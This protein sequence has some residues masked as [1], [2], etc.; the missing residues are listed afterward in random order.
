MKK[1]QHKD[2]VS[3]NIEYYKHSSSLKV[4]DHDKR[5]IPNDENVYQELSHN[6]FGVIFKDYKEAYKN[7]G[8]AIGK[9]VAKNA[10][11]MIDCVVSFSHDQFKLLM[12]DKPNNYKG[13]LLNHLKML[14]LK[15]QNEYGFEPLSIDF[16]MDEGKPLPDGSIENNYHAH[17]TFYNYDH[18]KKCA[19]LRKY[20]N[21]KSAFSKLQ[22]MT[23][24]VFAGLGFQRGVSKKITKKDHKKKNDYVNEIFEKKEEEL[25]DINK[26]INNLN[27]SNE[28]SKKEFNELVNRR[29][30]KMDHIKE[31]SFIQHEKESFQSIVDM[32]E[33]D[34]AKKLFELFEAM[35]SNP[36]TKPLYKFGSS[37]LNKIKPLYNTLHW[38]F[39]GKPSTFEVEAKK[40]AQKLLDESFKESKSIKKLRNN[41]PKPM[42]KPKF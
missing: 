32:V 42:P 19:P 17:L 30:I 36:I 9:K 18:V 37:L 22:T 4:D 35:E 33:S 12:E 10:N 13:V 29:E 16:H 5:K 27:Y 40:R 31:N 8:D 28:L 25:Y 39:I 14:G 24:D 20:R 6:N 41:N 38:S 1:T 11:T 23:G 7:H 3:S 21:N 26:T 2:F 15:I 34:K